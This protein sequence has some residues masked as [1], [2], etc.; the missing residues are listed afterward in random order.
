[1]TLYKAETATGDRQRRH[2][3]GQSLGHGEP[4]GGQQASRPT[5]GGGQPATA[6]TAF[7]NPLDRDGQRHLRKP[8]V[9]R[10]G[11]LR[12]A[13]ERSELDLRLGRKLHEQPATYQCV[14]TTNLGGVATS[15]TFT[16][17]AS[18]GTYTVGATAGGVEP[19]RQL[20]RDQSA[21][22]TSAR[23]PRGSTSGCHDLDGFRH[24]HGHLIPRARPSPAS[25]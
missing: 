7:T 23:S 1:M 2:A 11:D 20:Q 19:V 8:Q 13:V 4:G 22:F 21:C 12:R 15:S 10:L 24:R 6:G 5:I 25:R 14:A 17:N 3:H 16:A 18:R 9:R